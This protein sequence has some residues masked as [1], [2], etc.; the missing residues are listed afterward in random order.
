MFPKTQ[1]GFLPPA[2]QL[3]PSLALA[4][5]LCAPAVAQE[6]D[7]V[8]ELESRVAE[9]EALV[10]QLVESGA[11]AQAAPAAATAGSASLEARAEAV[12]EQKVQEMLAEEKAAQDAKDKQGG[13][14]IGGYVKADFM[15]SDFGGGPVAGTSVGRDFYVP[16]TVPVGGEGQSYT[17][18]HAQESRIFLNYENMT[19]SGDTLRAYVELDFLVG[20]NG[21]ERISNSYQPRMRH[22]FLQWN[23]W[24]FGQTW[25]TI[26]NVGA[27]PELLDFVGPSESTVFG[28]QVMVR[29]THGPW[30]LA[31]ENP[32]TTIT[33][34]GGGARIDA[35][36]NK[37]PDLVARYN[38]S[39]DWGQW[40]IAGILR[41]L[42]YE[43]QAQGIDS[44]ETGYGLSV[45]GKFNV[46]EK[47]D[48]RWMVSG[49]KGLGRYVGLNIVTGAALDEDGSLEAIDT[50]SAFLAYRHFWTDKLRS[51]A[52]LGWFS[53]DNPTELTGLNVTKEA[54]SFH[55]NLIWTPVPQLDLGVEYIFANRE[56][57]SGADGDL[58]R[59][60]FSAKYAY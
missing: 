44:N 23:K 57:E 21:D 38:F 18:F 60:Q 40:S 45:A 48:L 42:A 14:E 13:L 5:V 24:L 39:G 52:A 27:L 36:D 15:Y 10:K 11:A 35:D 54:Q 2:R 25:N 8:A 30:Q 51:S 56:V 50:L 4:V 16:I 41:E 59:F 3:I 55:A 28:R 1:V 19:D 20:D 17:D 47:D 12:A 26:F 34:F 33:T 6:D 37:V 7:R 43:N 53:A 46:G 32:E 22:A 58:S 9:L 49:G 29:Y 31:I